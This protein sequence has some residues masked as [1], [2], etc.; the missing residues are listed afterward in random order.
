MNLPKNEWPELAI[1]I[2]PYQKY[3]E[4]FKLREALYKGTLFPDLYR[5]YEPGKG[6]D[7][8]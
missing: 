3:G 4:T 7:S 5:P 1:A 6:W 8:I 2:I